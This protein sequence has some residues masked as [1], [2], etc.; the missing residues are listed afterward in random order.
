MP[1]RKRTKAQERS[2]RQMFDELAEEKIFFSQFGQFR[3][4]AHF[5]LNQAGL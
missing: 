4:L 2:L 3:E 5:V 1:E